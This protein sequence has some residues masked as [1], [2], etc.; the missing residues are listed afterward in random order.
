MILEMFFFYDIPKF[1]PRREIEFSIGLLRGLAP[2]SKMP[3]QM[4]LP[5]L[6][7]LKTQLQE[8]HPS[9]C[10]TMGSTNPFC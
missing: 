10:L 5:E 6:T 4:S 3:Y 7:E 1:P 2:I 9:K 8:I